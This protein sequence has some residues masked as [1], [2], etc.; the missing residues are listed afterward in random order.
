MIVPMKIPEMIKMGRLK[1]TNRLFVSSEA[2]ASWAMLCVIA[3]VML[4]M[5]TEILSL[6]KIVRRI[7]VSRANI[8]PEKLNSAA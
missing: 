3:P 8:P 4:V 5:R 7:I 2:M 6:N 1:K